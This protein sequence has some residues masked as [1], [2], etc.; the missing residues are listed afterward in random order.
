[1]KSLTPKNHL[2]SSSSVPVEP[3]TSTTVT[4][5]S[6]L[7]SAPILSRVSPVIFDAPSD[8][9]DP[10]AASDGAAA[11]VP[12]MPF[13]AS[14]SE[15]CVL[16]SDSSNDKVPMYGH[17]AGSVSGGSG[18]GGGGGGSREGSA[19]I[20]LL[21]S[22]NSAGSGENSTRNPNKVFPPALL[23][24]T[25]SKDSSPSPLSMLHVSSS[26]QNKK[27]LSPNN[28]K[29][30][31][32]GISM[33][34]QTSGNPKERISPSH[35]FLQPNSKDRLTIS[36]SSSLFLSAMKKLGSDNSLELLDILGNS[37][38]NAAVALSTI[39]D[40]SPAVATRSSFFFP[41]DNNVGTKK[42]TEDF[43]ATDKALEVIFI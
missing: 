9:Y 42:E 14:S 31:G 40:E 16:Q 1:M 19:I 32:D 37:T 11:L 4:T 39:Y 38:N 24:Q 41:F 25:N 12:E 23:V 3:V 26:K 5:T 33:S 22:L 20:Q 30:S 6:L 35:S 8:P 36:P 10:S 2:K 7:C 15:P 21:P 43:N 34:Q 28:S 18:G 29:N 13:V 17:G 27:N